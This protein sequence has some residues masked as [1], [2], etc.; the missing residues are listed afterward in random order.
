MSMQEEVKDFFKLESL[1]VHSEKNGNEPSSVHATIKISVNGDTEI[2]MAEGS[3][4]VCALDNVLRKALSKFYKIDLGSMR[5]I[6]YNANKI[7]GKGAASKVRVSIESGD[8][9]ENWTK[10][11][12][13]KDIVDASWQALAKSFRYKL[14]KNGKK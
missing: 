10:I 9:Y 5:L 4:H 7:E 1:R 2:T 12:I 11:A 8:E 14:A 13:A 3:G 6:D